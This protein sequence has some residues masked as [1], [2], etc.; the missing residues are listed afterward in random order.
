MEGHD[1]SED[2]TDYVKIRKDE[3]KNGIVFLS[4]DIG[5]KSIEMCCD[6]S[7]CPRCKA[8]FWRPQVTESVRIK[9]RRDFLCS[10]GLK[11]TS[12]SGSKRP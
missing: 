9:G 7:L 6:G 10:N 11:F 2:I 4:H 5:V 12:K 3:M 1:I 8:R